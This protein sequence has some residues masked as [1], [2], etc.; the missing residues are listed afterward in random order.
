M[1]WLTIRSGS[2]R[3]QGGARSGFWRPFGY[4]DIQISSKFDFVVLQTLD[5]SEVKGY[6]PNLPSFLHHHH[7]AIRLATTIT[8][9]QESGERGRRYEI[10]DLESLKFGDSGSSD[11]Q[12]F[13]VS[14]SQQ[15][16]LSRPSKLSI[17]HLTTTSKPRAR[18]TSGPK[19]IVIL[20]LRYRPQASSCKLRSPPG[21]P[22]P[23]PLS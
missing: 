3:G 12:D 9:F 22:K 14:V 21:Y 19:D 17:S 7:L 18:P 13:S 4:R 11:L 16:P 5:H 1:F 6:L 20:V 8:K 23:T 15:R 2:R 10:E